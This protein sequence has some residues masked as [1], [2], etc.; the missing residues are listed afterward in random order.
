MSDND[1]EDLKI[2]EK[3]IQGCMVPEDQRVV[4]AACRWPDGHMILGIRHFSPDMRI[5]AKLQGY[6]PSE[7]REQGF[8]DQWGNYLTR[9]EAFTIALRN[10][11]YRP[12]E[13][14]AIGTLYSEDLY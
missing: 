8:V 2:F 6:D 14:Y 3:E 7:S 4:C 5:S 10:G 12:Y 13:P 1:L 9:Q 11:Q